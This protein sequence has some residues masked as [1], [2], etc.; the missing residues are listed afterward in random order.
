MTAVVV[1]Q[2]PHSGANSC[3]G[4]CTG[5]ILVEKV[6]GVDFVQRLDDAQLTEGA[7]EFP[8]RANEIRRL[9]GK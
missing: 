5:Q 8:G 6:G 4:Q 9:P 7:R 2:P 3:P 1:G